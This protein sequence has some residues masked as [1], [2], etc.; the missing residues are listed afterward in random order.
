MQFAAVSSCARRFFKSPWQHKLVS[1]YIDQII[2]KFAQQQIANFSCGISAKYC[3]SLFR[4]NGIIAVVK[5]VTFFEPQCINVRKQLS[6]S[7]Q[8]N[9]NVLCRDVHR[10]KTVSEVIVLMLRVDS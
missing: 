5:W 6:Y 4:I 3:P 7:V 8:M 10:R 9:G 2:R 1:S